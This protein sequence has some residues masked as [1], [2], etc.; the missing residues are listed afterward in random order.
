MY[1]YI[2]LCRHAPTICLAKQEILNNHRQRNGI[3]FSSCSCRAAPSND[4]KL[5]E[6]FDSQ[7]DMSA[8]AQK[9]PNLAG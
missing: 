9:R 6:G 2:H 4:W 8:G 1:I 7:L 5:N 3:L